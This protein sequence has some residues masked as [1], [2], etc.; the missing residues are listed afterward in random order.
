MNWGSLNIVFWGEDL[1]SNIVL[2]SLIEAGHHI[3]LVLTPFYDNLIYKKLEYSCVKFGIPFLR[4]NKINSD[5][6]FTIVSQKCPNLC[7]IAHFEKLIKHPILSIPPMGFINLHPSMLPYYR[8]MSPQHWPLIN[9]EKEAGIT[10]HYVDERANTG[11]IILQKR[12]P[13]TDSMYVS[14]LQKTWIGYYSTIMTEAIDDILKDKPTISQ[15]DLIGSYYGKLKLSDCVLN[16]SM[17]VSEAYNLVRGVSLPYFRASL[18]NMTIYR[19]HIV[20]ENE[21]KHDDNPIIEFS[22]GLLAIDKYK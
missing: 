18:D 9:G 7:I 15:K 8:G 6:V 13:L 3:F 21:K 1:F 22:D 14:D 11:D 17:R 16:R 2:L 20:Q 5:E 12:F 4:A 10:I 19:A